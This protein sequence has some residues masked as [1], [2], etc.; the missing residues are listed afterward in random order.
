MSK[1]VLMLCDGAACVITH[2]SAPHISMD[3]LKINRKT[4]G[5]G[6]ERQMDRK[7]DKQLQYQRNLSLFIVGYR[8]IINTQNNEIAFHTPFLNPNLLNT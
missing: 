2:L 4:G 3:V 5:G 8:K 7:T 1:P 6:D